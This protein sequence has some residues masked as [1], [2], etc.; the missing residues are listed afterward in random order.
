MG[1]YKRRR[2]AGTRREVS[3]FDPRR[4]RTEPP[5]SARDPAADGGRER[6]GSRLLPRTRAARVLA[7][8]AV[9]LGVLG[10]VVGV[11]AA[12]VRDRVDHAVTVGSLLGTARATP[13]V[14][15][16]PLNFLLIGS[17]WR[18]QAP[19]NGE[20]AD[21]IMVV[22]IPAAHDRAYLVSIPRDLYY[23]IKPYRPTGFAGSTE[24]I[25]AALNFGGMPL[26]SQTAADLTGLKF[27]G[28]VVA[29]FAGFQKAVAALGGVNMCVDEETVSVHI[30]HDASGKFAAPFTDIDS[31][32]VPV[33]GVTPQVY[34]PGC[35]H[36]APWQALDYVRQRELLPGGDYDRQRHQQQLMLAVLNQTASAGMLSDPVKLDR[37]M[38]D[39]GQGLTVDSNGVSVSRLL[40][41]LRG[42]RT[43][44]VVGLKTPSHPQNMDDISYVVADPDAPGLWQAMRADSLDRFAATHPDMVNRLRSSGK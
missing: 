43:G 17:N 19:S 27:N 31:D 30:G 9:A 6:R 1:R 20:R 16:G 34:H 10:A 8:F 3:G 12:L 29:R 25:D 14:E 35:Q 23:T 41:L 36:L 37:V 38:R 18:E 42:I 44:S 5:T 26:M 11:G 33:P 39:I 2:N 28:A 40:L 21:S 15:N 32:P 7:V 22:H 4:A 24:K 13:G